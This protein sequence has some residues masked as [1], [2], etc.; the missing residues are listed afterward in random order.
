[1]NIAIRLRE[2]R[3]EKNMTQ[4]ELAKL[5]NS[6]KANISKYETG[7]VE[8]NIET[9]RFFAEYFDVSVD[10][11]LGDTN[12][13]HHTDTLAFH[14]DGDLTEEE[15]EEVQNYIEFLKSKRKK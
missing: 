11:L 6:T 2:L 3:K 13:K 10:Y 4:E 5:I 7:K 14:V 12:V 9:I 15:W 1:M 8:P